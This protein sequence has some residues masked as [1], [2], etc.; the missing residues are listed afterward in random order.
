MNEQDRKDIEYACLIFSAI[1][2]GQIV[3]LFFIL[4]L[5]KINIFIKRYLIV[6]MVVS[7]IFMAPLLY[8]RILKESIYVLSLSVLGVASFSNIITVLASCYLSYLFPPRWNYFLGRMPIYVISLGKG[9][10]ILL[11]LFCNIS[12]E[13]GFYVLF[14]LCV[15]F[16]G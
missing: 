15:I 13:I 1:F 12:V 6:F 9:L 14:A 8:V 7:F 3:S 11:C 2:L 16:Y 5:K 4:P 10:G